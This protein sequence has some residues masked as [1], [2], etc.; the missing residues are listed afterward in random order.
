MSAWTQLPEYLRTLAAGSPDAVLLETSRFDEQNLHSYLFL[1]P[2]EV[3]SANTTDEL[4]ALF[5]WIESCRRRGLHLAVYFA[6]ECGY[7]LESRSRHNSYAAPSTG[8]SLPLAWLGA[9]AEPFV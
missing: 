4:H 9:Y 8:D 6:Y 7:L 1:N 3:I 5:Q 2:V